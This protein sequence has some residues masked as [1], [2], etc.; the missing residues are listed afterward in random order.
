MTGEVE[1]GLAPRGRSRPLLMALTLAAIAAG[2]FVANGNDDRGVGLDVAVVEVD[3]VSGVA[4]FSGGARITMGQEIGAEPW[5]YRVTFGG[6]TLKNTTSEVIEVV[7]AEVVSVHKGTSLLGVRMNVFDSNGIGTMRGWTDATGDADP[8][9]FQ[10]PPGGDV[11]V[12]VGL[13]GV[14]PG[15]ADGVEVVYRLGGTTY[16]TTYDYHYE[17]NPVT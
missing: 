2:L 17:L 5:Q 6:L 8:E 15:G 4:L 9:G 11:Q 16:S 14:P 12:V 13:Q 10:I 1:P 3:D 7:S